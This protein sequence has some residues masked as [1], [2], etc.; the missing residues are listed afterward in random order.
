MY[1][2]IGSRIREA[3]FVEQDAARC[4]VKRHER[5]V[6]VH[7]REAVLAAEQFSPDEL[8]HVRTTAGHERVGGEDTLVRPVRD[9]GPALLRVAEM[10]RVTVHPFRVP[11]RWLLTELGS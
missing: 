9:V 10:T 11:S 8:R 3:D 1:E 4:F 5:R 6:R 7:F 2:F